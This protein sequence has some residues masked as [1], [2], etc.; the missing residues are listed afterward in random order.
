MESGASSPSPKVGL[1]LPGPVNDGGWTASAYEGIK[2]IK[3][4]YPGVQVSY[5]ENIPPSNFEEIFRAYA[6]QG[7]T[8]V[9]GH[10]Y[11]FGN[12]AVKVAKEFP[13][14]TFC[15]TSSDITFPPNVGSL[16][17]NYQEMGYLL[18]IIAGTMTKTNV[19]GAIG[20]MDIPSI[21][22]PAAAYEAAAK[23][24]NPRVKVVSVVTGSFEDAAKAKEATLAVI[25]RGAD[26]VFQN[27]DQAGLGVFE[28]CKEKGVMALGS[29]GDQ[30]AIAPDTILT[31]GVCSLGKGMLTVFDLFAQG[32]WRPESYVMGAAQDAVYAAPFRNFDSLVPEELKNRLAGI[33]ADMKSGAFDAAAFTEKAKT[34]L[35]ATPNSGKPGV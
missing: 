32:N 30:A 21:T 17:G 2:A 9:F 1:L 35:P 29:I 23:S 24:I 10:G 12:A 22:E 27:A 13:Q 19:I 8:M 31:S 4:K 18:G 34:P 25:E 33:Q 26:I 11:E 16:R 28:A 20:G 3:N 5:Q 6:S 15:V 7:Y 14:V